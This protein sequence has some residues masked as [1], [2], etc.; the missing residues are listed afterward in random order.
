MN[1]LPKN[2]L[3]TY[4]LILLLIVTSLIGLIFGIETKK[5]YQLMVKGDRNPCLRVSYGFLLCPSASSLTPID[6]IIINRIDN[7]NY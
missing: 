5:F 6:N 3:C 1:Q 7:T 4:N 2:S